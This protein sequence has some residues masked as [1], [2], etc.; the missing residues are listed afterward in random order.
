MSSVVENIYF[1][2]VGP[3]NEKKKCK[4]TK[5]QNKANQDQVRQRKIEVTLD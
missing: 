5:K 2:H 4:K 1:L 3:A